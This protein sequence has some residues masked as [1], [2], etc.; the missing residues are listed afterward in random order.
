VA[1]FF[2]IF[3]HKGTTLAPSPS[4]E[5]SAAGESFSVGAKT[6]RNQIPKKLLR[7]FQ[8]LNVLH[9]LYIFYQNFN[10]LVNSEA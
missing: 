3:C 6:L 8:I 7:L 9:N 1:I 10:Y 4:P 5:A 2:H